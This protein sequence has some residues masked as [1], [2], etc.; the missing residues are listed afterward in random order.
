MEKFDGQ[1]DALIDKYTEL[2]L[3]EVTPELKDKVTK[4]VIY[5]YIAKSMPP[6]AKHWNSEFPEGKEEIKRIIAEIK[7]MNEEHRANKDQ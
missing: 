5:T 7:E 3:G 2:L 6:L 4:W 1:F